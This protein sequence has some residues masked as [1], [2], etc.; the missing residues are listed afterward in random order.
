M[1]NPSSKSLRSKHSKD[2]E[3]KAVAE[4]LKQ[5]CATATVVAIALNIY[6]PNICRWK[7]RLEKKGQLAVIKKVKCPITKHWA[8]LLT[9]NPEYFPIQSQLK[10]FSYE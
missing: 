8:G 7:R 9:T 5:Q 4:Y 3:L 2:N 6:R 10:L 1:I